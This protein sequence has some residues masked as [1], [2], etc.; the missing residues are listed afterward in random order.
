[1]KKLLLYLVLTAL[2]ATPAYGMTTSSLRQATSGF[3]GRFGAYSKNFYAR[4]SITKVIA[5]T[6]LATGL[7]AGTKFYTT[8][9]I[10]PTAPVP[11]ASVWSELEK[12]SSIAMKIASFAR[13]CKKYAFTENTKI[14]ARTDDLSRIR[15]ATYNVHGWDD[16]FNNS[17]LDGMCKV[18]NTIDADVIILQEV[19]LNP[20]I[21]KTLSERLNCTISTRNF[22]KTMSYGW[23]GE[24]GN[25]VI[26]KL[27]IHAL[28]AHTYSTPKGR[29]TRCFIKAEL[30]LAHQKKL[31]I[32]GTHL[33]VRDTSDNES[34]RVSEVK[35]LLKYAHADKNENIIITG[36]F[37]AVR[38]EDYDYTVNGKSV[39]DMLVEENK[40]RGFPTPTNALDTLKEHGFVD[41]FTKA[42]LPKPRFTVWPGTAVD[43]IFVSP[44]W[45]LPLN[46]SY[47][48][49]DA[50]SDHLPV[51]LDIKLAPDL[52]INNT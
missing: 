47:V 40:K 41:S 4:C 11:T 19:V 43:F 35:E 16:P 5:A 38:K 33:E 2:S 18:I 30:V 42:Q 29:E 39:W 6:T 32:Y 31:S 8:K 28:T 17:N 26:S 20:Q 49:Y 13:D 23:H 1:M 45:N 12:N 36:D 24:F 9:K 50:A 21:I 14:P 3:A 34:T 37:N 15:I 10:E 44:T 22:C 7:A 46:G 51:I 25:L 27:P 52:K 48:Y